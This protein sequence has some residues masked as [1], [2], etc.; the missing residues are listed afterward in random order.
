MS[1]GVHSNVVV[2][3]KTSF[4]HQDTKEDV[5]YIYKI[6][7]ISPHPLKMCIPNIMKLLCKSIPF[8]CS[9]FIPSLWS[10][11]N[12]LCAT[13]HFTKHFTLAWISNIRELWHYLVLMQICYTLLR[14][15]IFLCSCILKIHTCVPCKLISIWDLVCW[16]VCL[17]I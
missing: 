1:N 11:V 17:F 16:F 10:I 14:S 9:G 12:A 6:W 4:N 5:F 15:D 3:P 13:D 8:N 7:E 2:N